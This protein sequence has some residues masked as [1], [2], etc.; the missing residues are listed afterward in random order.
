MCGL[1]NGVVLSLGWC[2]SEGLLYFDSECFFSLSEFILIFASFQ[3]I[4]ER[5]RGWA[6][7][8]YFTAA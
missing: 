4:C 1:N 8:T 2:L 3:I 5:V 6:T 7:G